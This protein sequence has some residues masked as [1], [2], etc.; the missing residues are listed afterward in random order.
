MCSCTNVL[1]LHEQEGGDVPPN[2]AP[3][4]NPHRCNLI[5]ANPSIVREPKIRHRNHLRCK[6]M[7]HLV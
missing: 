4:R 7:A 3:P 5:A 6:S 1:Q 2:M